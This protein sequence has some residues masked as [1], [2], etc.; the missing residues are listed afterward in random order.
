[1]RDNVTRNYNVCRKMFSPLNSGWGINMGTNDRDYAL[2]SMML[3][4]F[5]M[6]QSQLSWNDIPDREM[7]VLSFFDKKDRETKY[8]VY[9]GVLQ[10][11]KTCNIKIH[12]K[13]SEKNIMKDWLEE[14]G[15]TFD[16][17]IAIIKG[18]KECPPFVRK[19]NK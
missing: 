9:Q 2:T 3:F 7:V 6:K 14:M 11:S 15:V 17:L 1:M 4:A 5:G 12:N 19:E 10:G 18:E 16:D 13:I 8:G